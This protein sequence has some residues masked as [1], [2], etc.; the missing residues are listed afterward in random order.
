MPTAI[1]RRGQI[2]G[3]NYLQVG[4]H[5]YHHAYLWDEGEMHDLGTL[6]PGDP[7]SMSSEATAINDAGQ[8]VGFSFLTIEG[9]LAIRAVLWEDGQIRALPTLGGGSAAYAINERGVIV[10]WSNADPNAPDSRDDRAVLWH[11]DTLID[12]GNLGGPA[13]AYGINNAGVAVGSSS[14]FPDNYTPHA[15]VWSHGRMYDLNDRLVGHHPDWVLD[16][17]FGINDRGQ[18]VGMGLYQGGPRAFLLNPRHGAKAG[19][20]DCP[21]TWRKATT[22]HHGEDCERDRY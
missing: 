7:M 6:S 21:D 9:E 16:R 12:L 13:V 22:K 17:A 1:N 11:K 8:I 2:V 5:S 19:K 10:G 14:I 20:K 18:I 4:D 15:F 3:L